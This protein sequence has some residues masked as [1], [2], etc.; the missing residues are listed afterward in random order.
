MLKII[1]ARKVGINAL[2]YD[3]NKL[4]IQSSRWWVQGS[5]GREDGFAS[6]AK[7]QEEVARLKKLGVE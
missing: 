3:S 6:R 1:N 4:K 2:K 7:A 5:G